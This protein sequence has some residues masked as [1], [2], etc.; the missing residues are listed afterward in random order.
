MDPFFEQNI[1][2]ST[3]EGPSAQVLISGLCEVDECLR[4]AQY[5]PAPWKLTQEILGPKLK[6]S[7]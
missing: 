7:P 3:V 6:T 2:D 1:S 5:S 4:R